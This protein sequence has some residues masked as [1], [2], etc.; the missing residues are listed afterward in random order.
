M[1]DIFERIFMKPLFKYFA[2]KPLLVPHIFFTATNTS[3][4]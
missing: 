1:K 3:C 4:N 2:F